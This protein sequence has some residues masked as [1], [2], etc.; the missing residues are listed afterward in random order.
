MALTDIY[1]SLHFYNSVVPA[2]TP[3][4]AHCSNVKSTYWN[5]VE[6]HIL[7][8][9]RELSKHCHYFQTTVVFEIRHVLVRLFSNQCVDHC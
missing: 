6:F 8:E 3:T 1:G 9:E 4:G 7:G 2:L 5:N